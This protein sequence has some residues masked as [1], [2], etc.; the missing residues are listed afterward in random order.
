MH[1][2]AQSICYELKGDLS[3]ISGQFENFKIYKDLYGKPF[4]HEWVTKVVFLIPILLI[5]GDRCNHP[6]GDI[7]LKIY[8]LP[9]FKMFFQ[10][11]LTK[12]FKS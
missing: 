3:P 12:F 1:L 7:W 11:V 6:F 5:F 8:R 2:R 10:L 4:K 9:N